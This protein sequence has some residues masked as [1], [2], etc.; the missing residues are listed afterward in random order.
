[1]A[2]TLVVLLCQDREIN[3]TFESLQKYVLDPVNG[4]VA[5]VGT[6]S[7]ASDGLPIDH[8]WAADEPEDWLSALEQEG[9]SRQT[10][11]DIAK[12]DRM[13]FGDLSSPSTVGS[14]A[15]VLYWRRKM[16]LALREQLAHLQYE[17]FIVTRSD[18][19]WAAP[20]PPLPNFNRDKIYVL[21]GDHHKGVNDR[22]AMFHRSRASEFLSTTD[23]LFSAPVAT[24]V[25]M[26]ANG[27]VN[28]ES[29]L[30]MEWAENQL[31]EHVE[32]IPYLA[33]LI[34]SQEGTTR[35]SPGE[36]NASEQLFVKYPSEFS[37]AKVYSRWFKREKDWGKFPAKPNSRTAI[38]KLHWR[39]HRK[40]IALGKADEPHHR[41]V[42]WLFRIA[43][44]RFAKAL[45]T[46]KRDVRGIEA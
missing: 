44:R 26:K 18:F 1:M 33:Y 25:R 10:A 7:N 12:I 43:L 45:G 37:Q 40:E 29:F 6:R 15:I 3:R 24:A 13:I 11:F 23:R 39:I 27:V 2:K 17:W 21:N 22:F 36:W 46:L 5:L 38:A 4:E 34:R 30:R 42:F 19:L 8:Q 31:L 9:I 41:I 32:T 28:P 20:L 16:E 14:G 35:W